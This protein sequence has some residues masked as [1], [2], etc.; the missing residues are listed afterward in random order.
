[1][2][3]KDHL[4]AR[5]RN[6]PYDGD[7]HE[8]S[9]NDRDCVLIKDNNLYEHATLRV[10]YTTYDVR[11]EQ[12]TITPRTHRDIMVLAHEDERTH[13][14]WY[15]HVIR[16]F[17]VNVEYHDPVSHFCSPPTCMNFLF[18]R[19]FQHDNSLAGWASKRLQ[20]L[21]FIDQENSDMA[22]GFIDPDC[23]IRGTH[24][25]PA[26]AHSSTDKLLG[27]SFVWEWDRDTKH[28]NFDWCYYYVN[29]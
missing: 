15:A 19:W 5:L 16:I 13:P 12:D 7:E 3:L 14:Y 8:F 28:G 22:F 20:R 9:N 29:W 27:P 2:R 23:V 11:R 25:I 6:L 17:H 10:N 1:V 24:L 18:V 26:F 21:E 4:L